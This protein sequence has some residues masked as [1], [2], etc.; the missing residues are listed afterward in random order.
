M[1]VFNRYTVQRVKWDALSTHFL[2]VFGNRTRV[3]FVCCPPYPSPS[4][5]FTCKWKS[6]GRAYDLITWLILLK[7]FKFFLY[8]QN[9]IER[10]DKHLLWYC[11]TTIEKR[12]KKRCTLNYHLSFSIRNNFIAL[13]W[14]KCE[15]ISPPPKNHISLGRCPREAWF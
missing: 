1:F 3:W 13:L 7:S 12:L 10:I 6:R 8:V 14:E 5:F 4:N 9:G 11:L 2:L 15:D